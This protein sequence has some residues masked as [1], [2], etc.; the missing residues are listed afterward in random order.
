MKQR[1]S[2]VKSRS[3]YKSLSRSNSEFSQINIGND[4]S[5]YVITD[6][7]RLIP[8]ANDDIGVSI[9]SNRI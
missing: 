4:P 6:K 7:M 1:E 2:I 9:V 3:H 8:Y 5:Y